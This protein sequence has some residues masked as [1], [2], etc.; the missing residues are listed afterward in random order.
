MVGRLSFS[1][2]CPEPSS[3]L[4]HCRLRTII[5]NCEDTHEWKKRYLEVDDS[6][7]YDPVTRPSASVGE[8][9][10]SLRHAAG[11]VQVC[12]M[13]PTTYD[14]V[15]RCTFVDRLKLGSIN[16]KFASLSVR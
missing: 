16:T 10:V 3:L 11:G 2:H 6:R 7:E 5:R 1:R 15:V 14:T 13:V 12:E 9:A 4:R 8:E